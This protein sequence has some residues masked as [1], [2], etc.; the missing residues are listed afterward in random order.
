[1]VRQLGARERATA[2]S[3]ADLGKLH[4]GLSREITIYGRSVISGVRVGEA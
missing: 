4:F 3:R 2:R 1:M